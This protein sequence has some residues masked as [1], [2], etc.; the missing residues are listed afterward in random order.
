MDDVLNLGP[1]SGRFSV[2]SLWQI[3]PKLALAKIWQNSFLDLA[4]FSTAVLW[5]YLH[6]S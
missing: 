6:Y 5:G 2:E 4:G 3:Q 1:T